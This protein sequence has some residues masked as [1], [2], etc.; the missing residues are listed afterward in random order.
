[1]S[2]NV[3]AMSLRLPE[4]LAKELDLVCAVDDV[5]VVEAVRVAIG[6]YIAKRRQSPH[7]QLSLRE[8]IARVQQLAA[9]DG[10]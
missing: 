1:M 6:D 3:R 5:A 10:D 2:G 4:D 9:D 7:F 8:Y